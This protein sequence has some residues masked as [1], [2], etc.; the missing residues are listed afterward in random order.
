MRTSFV[1]KERR[2]WNREEEVVSE[3]SKQVQIGRE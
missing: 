2:G 1:E 3:G